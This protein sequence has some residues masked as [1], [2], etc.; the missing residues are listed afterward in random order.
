M[1][2]YSLDPAMCSSCGM[3]DAGPLSKPEWTTQGACENYLKL[4]ETYTRLSQK[5]NKSKETRE[6]AAQYAAA[7]QVLY[8]Q[9]MEKKAQ[10]AVQTILQ[11]GGTIPTTVVTPTVVVPAGTATSLP[12]PATTTTTPV[13]LDT[14]ESW[15]SANKTLLIVGGV[16][17]AG[18]IAFMLL[19]KK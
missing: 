4:V 8:N 11:Q 5:E 1:N 12:V 15:F 6:R 3:A 7:N 13:V 14:G 17:V 16:A 19:R 18:L 10:T 9:C 2:L